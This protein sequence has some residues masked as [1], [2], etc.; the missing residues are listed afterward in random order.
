MLNIADACRVLETLRDIGVTAAIDDFGIGHSSLGRL[1]EFPVSTLKIDRSF[2]TG[3]GE[4]PE[5]QALVRGV[6]ALGHALGLSVVAEGIETRAQ[7]AELRAMGCELGQGYIYSP[8]VDA[9]TFGGML[10]DGTKLAA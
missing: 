4:T 5:D 3:L 2:V 9:D 8:P 7:L 6:V 10:A 1:R